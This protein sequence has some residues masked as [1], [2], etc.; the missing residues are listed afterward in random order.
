M[1]HVVAI[2]FLA[3]QATTM[4]S[5]VDPLIADLTSDRV[6]VRDAAEMSLKEVDIEQI[7]TLKG[8]RARITDPDAAMRLD[9]VVAHLQDQADVGPSR[10]TLDVV[11]VPLAEVVAAIS[12]QSRANLKL[13]GPEFGGQW[14]RQRLTLNLNRATFWETVDALAEQNISLQWQ[15]GNAWMVG[16]RVGGRVA[17]G[18]HSGA[19]LLQPTNLSYH[20]AIGLS[21][22][23]AGSESFSFNFNIIAE[24]KIRFRD[25]SSPIVDIRE[26]IDDAGNSL[27]LENANT[28]RG[29]V[30]G[31]MI[32]S[33]VNLKYPRNPGRRISR[34]AGIAQ[35]EIAR[36]FDSVDITDI[37]QIT[38]Y[39][40]P[41]AGGKIVV[42]V[43]K[44]QANANQLP[45][46]FKLTGVAQEHQSAIQNAFATA[47][48]TNNAGARYGF[49]SQSNRVT[50]T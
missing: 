44:D 23:M 45:V 7:T 21:E 15:G 14:G 19:F 20:K 8:A 46:S 42:R 26:V 18:K 31:S 4:P 10:I 22:G 9:A 17:S 41:L 5:T 1:T 49:N 48:L 39:E 27:V 13:P 35:A 33:G 11:D 34:I 24:P 50:G 16:P 32:M 37:R 38:D 47:M 40:A 29:G 6:E 25:G 12:K 43:D 2:L 30:N 36:E 3:V 28:H